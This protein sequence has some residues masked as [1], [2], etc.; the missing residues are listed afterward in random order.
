MSTKLL[1][2]IGNSR[3]H[4][5]DGT[6]VWH[7][8]IDEAITRFG[9]RSL[10]YICVNARIKKRLKAYPLWEDVS[11]MMVLEGAYETMGV[12]RKALCLSHKEGIFI[13][14]GS[15]VTI[16][17]VKEGI[18]QGG[19]LLP[20]I[21][22]QQEAF[23]SISKALGCP[24]DTTLALEMLPKT[25]PKQIA[26]GIIA[27]IAM[28]SKAHQEGLPIYLTGGDAPLLKPFLI[29]AIVDE[30]LVFKGMRNALK[31]RDC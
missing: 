28:V 21:K 14:A 26:Y 12:D 9:N 15:A 11:K 29:D 31:E 23:R 6:K 7:L 16:D 18:Y 1:A 20:G 17:K 4:I 27:P 25:T 3:A 19:V 22:A 24:L 5:F 10:C 13:D 30:E 8:S 2:D